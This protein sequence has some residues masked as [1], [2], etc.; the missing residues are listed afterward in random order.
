MKKNK[1]AYGVGLAALFCVAGVQAASFQKEAGF[2]YD[3]TDYDPDGDLTI[4]TVGGTYYLAPVQASGPLAEAAFLAKASGVNAF[5][6]TVDQ[7]IVSTSLDGETYGIGVDYVLPANDIKLGLAMETYDVSASGTTIELTTTTLE[8]GKYLDDKKYVSL[9]YAMGTL[10]VT[11]IPDTDLTDIS[12]AG[13]WLLDQGGNTINLEAFYSQEEADDGT[14]S[15]TNSVIGISGDYYLDDSLSLG[16]GYMTNS[17][18][19]TTEEGS[20]VGLHAEKFLTDT[21]SVELTYSAFSSDSGVD[22]DTSVS[23]TIGGRF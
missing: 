11:T 2:T 4:M 5:I 3:K 13:K 18:D 20:T 21:F 17:G 1:I 16:L 12:L 9:S 22:D 7:T 10:S 15:E 8:F 14:V 23:L 19:D 6:G